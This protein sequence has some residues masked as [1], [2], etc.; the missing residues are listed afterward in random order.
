LELN[1]FE[2][3]KENKLCCIVLKTFAYLRQIL[4]SINIFQS[5]SFF[6]PK[7]KSTSELNSVE[8]ALF[9]IDGKGLF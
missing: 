9:S 6:G 5:V 8:I 7:H 3:L 2:E 1:Q 4:I